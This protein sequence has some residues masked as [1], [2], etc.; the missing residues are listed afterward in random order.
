MKISEEVKKS[1]SILGYDK[2]SDVQE[3]VLPKLF[4]DKNLVI[5]SRT[6]SGK[7]ASF[8]I[9]AIERINWDNSNPSVL[10]IAPTRE[11]VVQINEELTA[12]SKFK[13]Q[14]WIE[15]YGKSNMDVQIKKLKSKVHGVVAT[16]GRLIDLIERDAINL[17]DIELLIIDEADE[18][19][20]MGFIDDIKYIID[21]IQFKQ[22]AL[23]SASINDDV[24]E[25]IDYIGM[26]HDFI[27]VEKSNNI[28]VVNYVD[29]D[30]S[31]AK[32]L[33]N[34]K[35]DNA[36]IFC[37]TKELVESI[38]SQ[39]NSY[40]ISVSKLHGDLMQKDRIRNIDNFKKH[41]TR[42]LVASDV[43]SRGIDVSN[44]SLVINYNL[45]NDHKR[46]I[47]RMGRTGRKDK[48]GLLINI[49]SSDKL[50]YSKKLLG[51]YGLDNSISE[52]ESNIDISYLKKK[53]DVVDKKSEVIAQHI[54]R[55]YIKAGRNKKIRPNDIVGAL[56]AS[57]LVSFD[58]IGVIDIKDDVSYVEILKDSKELVKYLQNNPIKGS[59]RRVEIAK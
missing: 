56:M 8:G 37:E 6:G 9:Y 47:H 34:H 36:I 53:L 35:V 24:N 39:L 3:L 38:Y 49:L 55:I 46:I 14:N 58:E 15:V 16:V 20:S 27:S 22:F 54:D 44:L 11:L 48:N 52:L 25:I 59:L 43:A 18:M 17:N 10:V 2:L 40:G 7:T 42:I 5:N 1:M 29:C 33:S 51:N 32:V 4:D 31:I 30:D 21:M 19:C 13:R 41:M 50:A 23:L 28:D 45:P 12:L 57:N 26:D